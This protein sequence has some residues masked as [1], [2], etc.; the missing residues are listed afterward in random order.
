[1]CSK[2]NGESTSPVTGKEYT[3]CS[4]YKYSAH[5]G[6]LRFLYR[7][8]RIAKLSTPDSEDDWRAGH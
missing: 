8:L 6:H 7:L 1:M 4:T 3:A 2:E 5:C